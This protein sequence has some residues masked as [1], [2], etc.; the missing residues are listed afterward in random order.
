L[1]TIAHFDTYDE[2]GKD[3]RKRT[4]EEAEFDL[5]P[6]ASRSRGL[7]RVLFRWMFLFL[8]LFVAAIAVAHW[9]DL[10]PDISLAPG[11]GSWWSRISFDLPNGWRLDVHD[12]LLLGLG[13]SLPVILGNVAA[14]LVKEAGTTDLPDSTATKAMPMQASEVPADIDARDWLHACR[15]VSLEWTRRNVVCT[16]ADLHAKIWGFLGTLAVSGCVMVLATS[17][18]SGLDP[19][20]PDASSADVSKVALAVLAAVA[21][22]FL[23]SFAQVLV[24]SA[25]HDANT[26]LFSNAS[27]D[28]VVSMVVSVVAATLL[29]KQGSDPGA[30]GLGLCAGLLG[31]RALGPLKERAASALGVRVTT[32]GSSLCLAMIEGLTDDVVDR[33]GEERIRSVHALATTNTPRIYFSTPYTWEQIA[34]WQAQAVLLEQLGLAGFAKFKER[35]PIR[36]VHDALRML[37]NESS[38]A[39]F[40]KALGLAGGPEMQRVIDT[41][42]SSKALRML[43][44]YG[45]SGNAV[46]CGVWESRRRGAPKWLEQS[47]PCDRVGSA[48]GAVRSAPGGRDQTGSTVMPDPEPAPASAN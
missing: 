31:P 28:L 42:G 7:F 3:R 41:L 18:A 16:H 21:I 34:D 20:P 48:I 13:C 2:S 24:R 47:E 44:V 30:V 45:K 5:G 38:L 19:S 8:S 27:R 11:P 26:A 14:R 6:A 46:L 10:P 35:S 43:E 15:T 40:A 37:S 33:L 29:A 22:S 1:A 36:G 32:D 17:G 4:S 25:E 39:D 9:C 12:A 23:L